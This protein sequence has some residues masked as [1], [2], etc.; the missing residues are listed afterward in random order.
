MSRGGS[1]HVMPPQPPRGSARA[2][3]LRWVRR[4]RPSLGPALGRPRRSRSRSRRRGHLSRSAASC[5]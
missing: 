4:P 5:A 1:A 3:P 2:D